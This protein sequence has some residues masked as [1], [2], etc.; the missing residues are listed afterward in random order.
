MTT[1]SRSNPRDRP[2]LLIVDDEP[3]VLDSLQHLFHRK[4][5]IF[6]ATSAREA[7]E[8]LENEPIQVILSDQRMPGTTG[9]ELLSQVRTR[10]PDTMRL[11]FTGYA[12]IQAVTRAVNQGGIFRYILKPWDPAELEAVLL[13]AVDQYELVAERRRLIVELQLS[14]EQ[15][16]LLNLELEKSNAL[17]IA[18]LEVASHELKTPITIV[19]LLCEILL[20]N[21]PDDDEPTRRSLQQV[22]LATRQLDQRVSTM[23]QLSHAR[24]YRTPLLLQPVSLHNLLNETA[25]QLQP[26]IND[27]NLTLHRRLDP[28]LG[29]PFLDA[30]KIRDVVANLLSNAIRFTPD[31]GTI[32]LS[33]Q[34]LDSDRIQIV[35]SDK[36]IGVEPEALEHLFDPFFTERDPSRHSSG[37]YAF[38]SRGLGIGLS[39]VKTFIEMH[40]GSVH[41][42]STQG[43]GTS[44][45]VRLPIH[46]SLDT[47]PVVQSP[48][49][50][51]QAASAEPAS[52]PSA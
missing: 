38:G 1:D 50:Y 15:L 13:Q 28:D 47:S 40:G 45:T 23:L 4:F 18:F 9:D 33:A 11:L 24:D 7:L 43:Q 36:G 31:G 35:V 39:L 2:R 10:W 20:K 27:R 3:D 19:S 42:Q 34:P 5:H 25:D 26:V 32:T 44:I 8:V 12:D 17:K 16:T 41:A 6:R 22:L 46:P 52:P 37:D 49:L 48:T 14:N 21:H 29:H 30:D 51:E